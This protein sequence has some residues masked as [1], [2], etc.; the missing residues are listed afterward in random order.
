MASTSNFNLPIAPTGLPPV[1][2]IGNF[3]QAAPVTVGPPQGSFGG[4]T[5]TLPVNG[6]QSVVNTRSQVRFQ[7]QPQV[8]TGAVCFFSIRLGLMIIHF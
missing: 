5:S 2:S 1:T 4:V 6:S 8:S 7:V 3:G